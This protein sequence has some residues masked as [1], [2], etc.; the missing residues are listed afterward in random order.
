MV[1]ATQSWN[2]LYPFEFYQVDCT[3]D[4]TVFGIATDFYLNKEVA[5]YERFL[6][7]ALHEL[8]FRLHADLNAR[9]T[10][11]VSADSRMG[12]NRWLDVFGFKSGVP[13]LLWQARPEMLFVQH[14]NAALEAELEAYQRLV[15]LLAANNGCLPQF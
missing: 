8:C 4:E 15:C 7:L 3:E 1:D 13:R 10:T 5:G 6:H 12:E 14:P 9:E 2:L 11:V